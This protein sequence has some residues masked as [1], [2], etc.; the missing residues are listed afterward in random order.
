MK[1]LRTAIVAAVM[2]GCCMAATAPAK[3]DPSDN[4]KWCIVEKCDWWFFNCHPVIT[5]CPNT[6]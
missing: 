4:G 2:F 3:A 6:N 1:K 5:G